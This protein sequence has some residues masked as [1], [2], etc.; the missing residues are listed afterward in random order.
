M[1]HRLHSTSA[2]QV[3]ASRSSAGAAVLQI[4]KRQTIDRGERLC[5]TVFLTDGQIEDVLDFVVLIP[6]LFT[7]VDTTIL[8]LKSALTIDQHDI[9]MRDRGGARVQVGDFACHEVATGPCA[10]LVE[11]NRLSAL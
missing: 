7:H 9:A 1:H 4:E 11:S 5:R 8:R 6:A 3:D 2:P 10:A